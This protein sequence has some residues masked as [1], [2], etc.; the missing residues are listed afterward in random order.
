MRCMLLDPGVN[1]NVFRLTTCDCPR[2]MLIP[3]VN[4]HPI[5]QNNAFMTNTRVCVYDHFLSNM[6]LIKAASMGVPKLLTPSLSIPL[7]LL[8]LHWRLSVLLFS[9]RSVQ[10][11][12]LRMPCKARLSL[13]NIRI[14][15]EFIGTHGGGSLQNGM[16]RMCLRK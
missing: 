15:R 14:W 7:P 13:C 11:S 5:H 8:C 9:D 2:W 1:S 6:L 3:G 12:C 16:V 4:S 10:E